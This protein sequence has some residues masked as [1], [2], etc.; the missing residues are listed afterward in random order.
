MARHDLM[1]DRRDSE[2]PYE[3]DWHSAASLMLPR[4][5]YDQIGGFD[6]RQVTDLALRKCNV[7]RRARAKSAE[8]HERVG[9][10]HDAIS[11]AA[12]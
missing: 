6:E 3:V 11:D 4:R 10:L 7:L 5:V 9:A 1:A 2:E 8:Q 12:S